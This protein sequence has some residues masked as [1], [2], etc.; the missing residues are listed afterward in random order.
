MKMLLGILLLVLICLASFLAW[1]SYPWTLDSDSSGRLLTVASEAPTDVSENPSVIKVLTFNIGFLFGRGSEGPGYEFRERSFYE[2]TLKD[3]SQQMRDWGADVVLLQEVDFR[4]SRSHDIN[5]AQFIAQHAGYPYV[6]EAISWASNYVP[7][8]FWPVKNHFGRMESG[9]AILSRYPLSF[10]EVRL[11]PKPK[12][13]AWWYNL[14]YPS[15]Y[16]HSVDVKLGDKKLKVVNLH[17]EAFD[18]EN[19]KSQLEIIV[20]FLHQTPV[21]LVA[22]DFNMLPHSATK[23]SGFYNSDNYENDSSFNVMTE[24]GLQ[25]VIPD[26]IYAKEESLYFTFPAW[27]PDR[28]LDY[29]W[30]RPDLKMMKAEVLPSASSDHLPLR[31]SF[32]IDGPRFNPYSQ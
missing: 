26:S 14:F 4:A 11:L 15:R 32:Q 20:N 12:S 29:I 6:A 17:L 5:Q 1:S 23:R 16:F 28:R 31:A 24:S 22:G 9:G 30:Y 18:K 3:V 10:H 21:D 8:P 2:S 7:F 13:Q 19:R 25:E 27:D